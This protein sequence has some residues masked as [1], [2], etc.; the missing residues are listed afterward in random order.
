M[1][2]LRD[3]RQKEK[4][5]RQ[6]ANSELQSTLRALA[7]DFSSFSPFPFSFKEFLHQRATFGLQDSFD[8]FHAMIQMIRIANVKAR[9]NG[10]GLLVRSA[11][12]QQTN[13]RLNQRAR[14]HR[15]GLY[16]RVNRRVRE[17]VVPEFLGGFAQRDDFRVGRWITVRARP[18]ASDR[19]QLIVDCDTGT[20]RDFIPLARFVRCPESHSHPMLMCR[21]SR[22]IYRRNH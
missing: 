13:A 18:I 9:L 12:Y 15:A 8:Y 14:A 20:D 10:A 19:Q 3:P 5:R 6:R 2:P 22:V 11:I 4:V 7:A 21:L 16:G 1:R 17:P